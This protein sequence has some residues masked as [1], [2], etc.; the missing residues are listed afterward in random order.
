M[1]QLIARFLFS[2]WNKLV[3]IRSIFV[4]Q[5]NIWVDFEDYLGYQLPAQVKSILVEN[6]FD[7]VLSISELNEEFI[8]ILEQTLSANY[9]F[10]PGHRALLLGL[11]KKIEG[12][13]KWRSQHKT[14]AT[15]ILISPN[16]SF[17]FKEL[18]KTALANCNLE[19]KQRRYTD[20]I[21]NFAMYLYIMCGRQAYEVLSSNLPLPQSNTVCEYFCLDFCYSYANRYI[22]TQ[23]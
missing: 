9:K 22:Q 7:N 14:A 1:N 23:L 15:D 6:K 20:A 18:V 17:I 4:L 2:C 10:L 21:K 13:I 19:A 11:P 5:S 3:F 16:I 8:S 12:F